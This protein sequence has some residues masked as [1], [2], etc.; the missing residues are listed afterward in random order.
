[1]ATLSR[2]SPNCWCDHP[3]AGSRLAQSATEVVDLGFDPDMGGS[4]GIRVTTCPDCGQKWLTYRLEDWVARSNRW[5]CVAVAEV[6]AVEDCRG[7]IEAA[8][9][10][11]VGGEYHRPNDE[12]GEALFT[13]DGT[14]RRIEGFR[15]N[16]PID[17]Y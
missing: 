15:M 2:N 7:L 14:Q 9:Y 6:P 17:L 13:S 11:Y 1:M 12:T 5:Y 3:T 16:R 4:D 8:D 10:C